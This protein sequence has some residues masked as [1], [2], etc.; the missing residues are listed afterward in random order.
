MLQSVR[1]SYWNAGHALARWRRVLSGDKSRRFREAALGELLRRPEAVV[2][3]SGETAARAAAAV[4]WLEAAQ[5]ATADG[6]VSYGW[7]PASPAGGWD[8]S[9]PETTGYIITSLIAYARRTGREDLI[10][11]A[12]RMGHW[13][14][15]IQM[16]SGA[17]Q[18]GKLT[19]PDRRS[20]AVFNTGMVLDGLVSLLEEGADADLQR[21]AEAAGRFLAADLDEA[22]LFA[23]NGAYVSHEAV[24]VYTVLCA[25]AMYRLG[26]LTGESSTCEA[27]LNAV[28]GALRFQ[29]GNGW[30]AENCLN[31]PA[32]PLTHTIGY[33]AQG[34]L[35][36]GLAA[37]RE[38]FIA[39]AERCLVGALANVEANG[40]LP[41][42]LD[43]A[44]RP[45]VRWVCLTGSAQL[46]IVAYRLAHARGSR[47]YR[48][49]ADRLMGFLKAVQRLETGEPGIDGALAGSYPLMGGYMSGG[50]PNW[51]TKYL[52]DALMLEADAA[53]VALAAPAPEAT[54]PAVPVA[55]AVS[56]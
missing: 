39:A 2:P 35:E 30:F 21:A 49:A 4:R 23:S 52:L 46:A 28:E 42:R 15:E 20:P 56:P 47:P 9:Y 3:V 37:G 43:A 10:A 11:R 48:D 45:A 53:G 25:W 5:D 29:R 16:P 44:W 18:G 14:A 8:V 7:F 33:A 38:D 55:E 41:G 51:A 19:T 6:G 40:A 22:G 24:K 26:R 17:V 13:E 12:R 27:A 36:V 32:H 50:Y 1:Q 54:R 31:D 34:V